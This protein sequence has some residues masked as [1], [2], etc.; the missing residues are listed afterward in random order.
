MGR[1][2]KDLRYYILLLF[3][4]FLAVSMDGDN[5]KE[6]QLVPHN[7]H[8]QIKTCNDTWSL[9][10][11]LTTIKKQKQVIRENGSPRSFA[12]DYNFL[13]PNCRDLFE[14]AEDQSEKLSMQLFV[15][16]SEVDCDLFPKKTKKIKLQVLNAF[17]KKIKEMQKII[18]EAPKILQDKKELFSRKLV[19]DLIKS[20]EKLALEKDTLI[21]ALIQAQRNIKGIN[22]KMEKKKQEFGEN[23]EKENKEIRQKLDE[24]K[25]KLQEYEESYRERYKELKENKTKYSKEL[26]RS[27]VWSFLFG[28]FSTSVAFI[29]LF[30]VLSIVHPSLMN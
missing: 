26:K 9:S 10:T 17:T 15:A 29:T 7:P 18:K 27:R 5:T 22:S 16:I 23:L 8:R 12:L 1:V 11:L 13:P 28:V 20:N 6:H 14:L 21:N 30:C 2:M 4:P 25:G 24:G 19:T 3:F